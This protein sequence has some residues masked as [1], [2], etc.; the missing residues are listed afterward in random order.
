MAC[1]WELNTLG[2]VTGVRDS[3]VGVPVA[4]CAELVPE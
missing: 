4:G 2:W 3:R 1:C